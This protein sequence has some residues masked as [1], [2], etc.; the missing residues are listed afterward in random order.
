MTPAK[1]T[2]RLQY[3]VSEFEIGSNRGVVSN[4]NHVPSK[5]I[6]AVMTSSR[7]KIASDI[8]IQTEQD[9]EFS[10]LHMLVS[11]QHVTHDKESRSAIV[12]ISKEPIAKRHPRMI[13]C[14]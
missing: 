2:P 4:M 5:I 6:T 14:R 11:L 12:K 7:T 3:S 13:L 8:P 9:I 1:Y 10:V